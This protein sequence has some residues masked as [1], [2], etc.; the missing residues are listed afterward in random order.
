VL[1]LIFFINF[2]VSMDKCDKLLLLM[3]V[4]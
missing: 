1:E 2:Y 3:Y 4:D